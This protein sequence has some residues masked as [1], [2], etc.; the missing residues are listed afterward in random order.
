MASENPYS[1]LYDTA[2]STC[3]VLRA[4]PDRSC[5]DASKK[6][7]PLH[8]ASMPQDPVQLRAADLQT[9]RG[10]YADAEPLNAVL[11]RRK[12]TCVGV[13][14]KVRYVPGRHIEV[15]LDDGTRRLRA[16]FTGRTHL[17]GVELGS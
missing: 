3:P 6:G 8:F 17:P 12:A 4:W 5:A 15:T 10:E 16:V 13:V 1:P 9:W 14:S 7:A 2:R 11:P